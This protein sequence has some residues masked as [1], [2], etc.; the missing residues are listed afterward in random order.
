MTSAVTTDPALPRPV[1]PSPFDLAP[2]A[3]DGRTVALCV[4]GLTGTPYEVRPLGEAIAAAGVRAVG[5]L[6]PGHNSSPE[7]LA[8]TTHDDWL[9]AVRH[10]H[11]RLA[12]EHERVYVVG[13]SLGGLLAL[14][15]AAS[16]PVA[17]VVAVG[18]PLRL[19]LPIPLLVPLVKH[20]MPMLKK[21]DGS[22]IR[23]PAARVRHPGYRQMPLAS[24][25]ELVRLQTR[26]RGMLAGV[27]APALIAHGAQD[28]TAHPSNARR[29]HEALGSAERELLMLENSAHVVP[30]DHDGHLLA[31][32]VAAFVTRI[33]GAQT[34]RADAAE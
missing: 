13:L 31:E 26:V 15:L 6:L 23:D 30:V 16:A 19:T 32:R 2:T 5:I 10:A 8:R 28:R 7:M 22:D 18:T 17:G 24:I 1:D 21:R 9:T 14:A 34:A 11:A 20:V 12:S 33:D 3:T 27:T 25:H 29:I 4:H